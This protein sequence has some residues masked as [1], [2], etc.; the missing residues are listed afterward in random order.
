MGVN[1]KYSIA[2]LLLLSC[3]LLGVLVPG[4]FVETRDFSHI[5][6]FVLG[7]FNAFLT[8]LVMISLLI[9]YY[10]LQDINWA[11]IVAAICSLS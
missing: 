5:N 7:S 9:I 4:G 3:G 6:P 11:Y 10:L 8:L 2:I 1:R